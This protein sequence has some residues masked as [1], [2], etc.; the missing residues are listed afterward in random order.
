MFKRVLLIF[1]FILSWASYSH[2]G[3][4]AARPVVESTEVYRGQT[5]EFQIRVSG[6][7]NP[8]QPNLSNLDDFSV[9]YRGGSQNSR[10]SVTIINGKMTKEE[11][12]GYIFS[13]QF[14][15]RKTGK[16]IIPAI[17][18]KSGNS[19]AQTPPVVITVT[20]PSETEDFKLRLTLSK[21]TCYA[22]EPL[23]LAV[24][25]YIGKDVQDFQFNLPVISDNR[26]N[27]AD[28]V[29]DNQPG[30]QLYR[31]QLG[32]K[33]AIGEKGNGE[34][35]G[36]NY[37]T[38]TFK[39]VLI[40]KEPGNILIEPAT[41]SCRALEGYSRR[42]NDSLSDLFDDDFFAS[43]RRAI[44]KTVVVPSNSL[45]L[46][47]RALPEKGK[48]AGF[49]G[50]IGIYKIETSASPLNVN[51]GDPITLEMIISGPE[52]LEHVELP[53]LNAQNNFKNNFKIPDERAGAA[54]QGNSKVFTQTIRP[55]NPSVKAIPP[56]ELPYFDTEKGK[57]LIARSNSIPLT[58]NKTR[59]VTLLDAEGASEIQTAGNDIETWGKGIAFNYED[60]SVLERQ[61]LTPLAFFKEGLWPLLVFSPPL[62]YILLLTGV[63]INRK[64]NSDPLKVLSRKAFGNLKKALEKAESASPDEVCELVL[65]SFRAYLGVKLKMPSGG[66]VTFGDVKQE[67]ESSGVETDII[68]RLKT[69]FDS[70]EAGRYAGDITF[71]D[72]SSL[73]N[74]A[75]SIARYLEKRL[76]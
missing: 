10:S 67:L 18:I 47:V 58:V 37:T 4:L 24:T 22:G 76:K 43:S 13:Y 52:Y 16:L 8:E 59:V 5:F 66:A 23:I 64:R 19:V 2:A 3:E 44:Y 1:I 53:P 74:E 41:V 48:P 70:C 35:D 36:K 21:E 60:M 26:F 28:P 15:P 11:Q 71:K 38:M 42:R 6:S 51:V 27:F 68:E 63:T 49:S 33:E 57:Y 69:M 7:E 17:E 40:P 12:K 55:L 61:Q 25:W 34:L 65:D 32:D 9:Q 75:V 62:V 56:V 30:R 50:H 29:I 14:T 39:K 73:I 31:I 72:N 54:I 46:K 20:E 45:T